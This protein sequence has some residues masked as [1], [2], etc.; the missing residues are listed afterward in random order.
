MVWLSAE[1][2]RPADGRKTTL[3]KRRRAEPF[4]GPTILFVAVVERKSSELVR[5]QSRLYQFG[6]NDFGIF[7]GYEL[8]AVKFWKRDI[9]IA[10][11]RVGRIRNS[12]TKDQRERSDDITKKVNLYTFFADGTTNFSRSEHEFR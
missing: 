10:D 8:T 12:S 5:D 3:H 1:C 6:K 7:P 4:T 11:G 2:T 9:Q